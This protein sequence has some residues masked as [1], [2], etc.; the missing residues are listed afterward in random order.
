MLL[1]LIPNSFIYA[2]STEEIEINNIYKNLYS[3]IYKKIDIS[4]APDVDS[5]QIEIALDY[6]IEIY[7]KKPDSMEAY[8][9][10]FFI[11]HVLKSGIKNKYDK[12]KDKHLAN[13]NDP[14]FETG[15]K[16][17]FLWL[18]KSAWVAD[19]MEDATN[20]MQLS[21]EAFINVKE[22]C[23]NKNYAAL[24]AAA[25]SLDP[26][27]QVEFKKF[28]INNVP[29]HKAVPYILGEIAY[30]ENKPDYVKCIE[31]LQKLNNKFGSM[32]TSN[33]WKLSLDYYTL[34]ANSYMEMNDQKNAKL[35]M[36]IIEKEAPNHWAINFLKSALL[37]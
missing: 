37:Q 8:F 22:N 21:N 29:E 36:E 28:I 16:L 4:N 33:G 31:E 9:S 24:A 18:L 15:E 17:V 1:M 14:D 27:K 6:I 34:I 25:L 30:F 12:M 26:I 32:E 5:T 35:Y 20:K 13:L 3:I 10:T 2:Q 23:K 19:S 7:K 11:Q